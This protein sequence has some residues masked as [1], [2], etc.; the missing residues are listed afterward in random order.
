MCL[1][2]AECTEKG[3][4]ASGTCASGF[5]SC[6][7]FVDRSDSM[8]GMTTFDTKV[9]YLQSPG[10]PQEHDKSLMQTVQLVPIDENICQ[11]RLDFIEF[12]TDGGSTIDKQCDRDM[13][14]VTGGGGIDLGVGD[15]C[16]KNTGQ[17]LYIPVQ[18]SRGGPAN[19]RIITQDRSGG[20]FSMGYKWN[21][22][23]TQVRGQALLYEALHLVS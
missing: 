6:C 4:E 3:G 22:K 1:S 23:V 16:G 14:R 18:G 17:H 7:A 13:F 21:V 10:F 20:N 11:I 15:L 12:Q 2:D 19:I 5:G 8:M 9:A